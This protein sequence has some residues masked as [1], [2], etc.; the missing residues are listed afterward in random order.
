MYMCGVC[1]CV[2]VCVLFVFVFVCVV[3]LFVVG[4]CF[5]GVV[6]FKGG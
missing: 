3:L 6:V 4:C 2:C 5:F 1:V